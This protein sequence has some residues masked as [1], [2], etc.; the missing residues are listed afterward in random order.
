MEFFLFISIG[1][2]AGWAAGEITREDGF[3]MPA[4]IMVGIAGA[5]VGGYVFE[6][7]G[8][9]AYGLWGALGFAFVTAVVVLAV[10]RYVRLAYPH[11]H[12]PS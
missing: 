8:L 10:A 2:I 5:L 6:Y 4:E 12:T 7:T 1:V 9:N 3:A 11:R